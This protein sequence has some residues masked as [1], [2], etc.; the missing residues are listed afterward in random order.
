M[1]HQ[2]EFAKRLRSEATLE[3]RIMW[4][5]LRKRRTDGLRFRRQ[6]PIGPYIVDFVCLEHRF[7]V[8]IDGVQHGD[9]VNAARDR[10]RTS[11]LNSE[12]YALF[13]A[14]NWEI[15]ENLD[16]VMM[17]LHE[18]LGLLNNPKQLRGRI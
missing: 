2:R 18:A 11:W 9:P 5:Q 15:R 3:E 10:V 1:S 17:S 16:G 14:W 6:H 8:E 13:R 7:I 4:A 12:G